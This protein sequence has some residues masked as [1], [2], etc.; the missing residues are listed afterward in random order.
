MEQKD[1]TWQT[2][3]RCPILQCDP[4]SQTNLSE[5]FK[6]A[7][8]QATVVFGSYTSLM[9]KKKEKNPLTYMKYPA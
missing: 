7:L 3:G 5:N 4:N 9:R 6:H 2:Y 1:S 8:L